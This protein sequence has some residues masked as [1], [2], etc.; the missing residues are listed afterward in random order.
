MLGSIFALSTL[1][2]RLSRLPPNKEDGARARTDASVSMDLLLRLFEEDARV[3]IEALS[4]RRLFAVAV[5]YVA[6]CPPLPWGTRWAGIAWRGEVGNWCEKCIP[7]V[8]LLR[9]LLDAVVAGGAAECMVVRVV[10]KDRTDG[11]GD[12]NVL[13]PWPVLTPPPI[14]ADVPAADDAPCEGAVS[15]A[16]GRPSVDNAGAEGLLPMH[17]G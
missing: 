10:V 14:V 15:E 1:S 9:G 8:L 5:L 3:S 4:V 11:A 2:G 17:G 6:G 16:D 12:E 13:S 7:C